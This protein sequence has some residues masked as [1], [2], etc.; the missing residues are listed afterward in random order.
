M[1]V[2]TA[3][4]RK[5]LS[6]KFNVPEFNTFLADYFPLVFNDIP[7]RML[8]S[9]RIEVLLER[10]RRD[11]RYPDL[12][13][14]L[15]RERPDFAQSDFINPNNKSKHNPNHP[16]FTHVTKSN[17]EHLTLSDKHLSALDFAWKHIVAIEDE[18]S[19]VLRW[20]DRDFYPPP[21][22]NIKSILD[23]L[24]TIVMHKVE[25]EKL[26]PYL[27]DELYSLC[28]AYCEFF[29]YSGQ[30]MANA[31][32][33]LEVVDW[34]NDG[35]IHGILAE[36]NSPEALVIIFE[37]YKCFDVA[38]MLKQRIVKLIQKRISENL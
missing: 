29:W 2:D 1:N 18:H 3:L 4:L 9:E 26:W 28:L 13:A 24:N 6:E 11:G 16:N 12:F 27:G 32:T 36:V 31:F 14:A 35:T 19:R 22:F 33:G 37:K 8:L 30:I 38:Q 21:D 17:S 7:P 5:Y 20:N 25:I 34:M 10:C 23:S 15:K